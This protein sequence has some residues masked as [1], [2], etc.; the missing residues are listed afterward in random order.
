ML[1]LDFYIPSWTPVEQP[2]TNNYSKTAHLAL[3]LQTPA[4][5]NQLPA[6]TDALLYVWKGTKRQSPEWECYH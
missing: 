3:C 2:R 4:K 1:I 5:K 6:E